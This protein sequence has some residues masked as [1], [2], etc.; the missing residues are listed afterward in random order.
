MANITEFGKTPLF[1]PEQLEQVGVRM[2]LHPLSCFRAMMKASELCLKHLMV[3]GTA[4]HFLD[5]MQTRTELYELLN[6]EQLEKKV[7]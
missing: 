4:E 3:H 7:R 2:M 6:Y 1:T 5:S